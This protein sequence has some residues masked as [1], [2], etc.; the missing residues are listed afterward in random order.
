MSL[1]VTDRGHRGIC[2]RRGKYAGAPT[3][4]RRFTFPWRRRLGNLEHQAGRGGMRQQPA[5][6]VGDARFGGG[7]AAADM[8]RAALGADRAGIA[9]SCP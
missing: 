4:R 6:R 2:R 3:G 8:Q 9:R 7:G 1:P 5:L